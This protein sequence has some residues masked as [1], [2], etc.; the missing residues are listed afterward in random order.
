MKKTLIAL[1]IVICALTAK[2]DVITNYVY[3]VSN[4]F[5]NVY[6][7][8]VITQKVK[9]THTDY[10]F[11]NYVS[12]VTNVYQT[13]FQTNI[14]VDVIFDNF[15]PW[16]LAASNHAA[17][18]ESFSS[19]AA[20]SATTAGAS[21]STASAYANQAWSAA[22]AAE[23]AASSTASGCANILSSTVNA[24]TN[25]F[26]VHTGEMVTN[27]NITATTNLYIDPGIAIPYVNKVTGNVWNN[28]KVHA[29]ES[30]GGATVS[31]YGSETY[32][33]LHFNVWPAQ[34]SGSQY[35]EFGPAYIDSDEYGMRLQYVPTEMVEIPYSDTAGAHQGGKI[36]PEYLYWQDG[37]LYF[38]ANVWTNSAIAGYCISRVV[39]SAY[40]RPINYD[41]NNGVALA[42]VSRYRYGTSSSSTYN[43]AWFRTPTRTS[44]SFEFPQH[45]SPQ[46]ETIFE[47][48][49]T[50]RDPSTHQADT[51]ALFDMSNRIA[52]IAAAIG[53]PHA[54]VSPG[55]TTYPNVIYFESM[56]TDNKVAVTTVGDYYP[57][58]EYRVVPTDPG[59]TAN[60][61]WIFEPAYADTDENGLRLHYLP[62][63]QKTIASVRLDPGCNYVP[64]DFYWQNGAIYVVIDSYNGTTWQGR[65][66]L[67]LVGVDDWEYPSAIHATSTGSTLSTGQYAV[68]IYDSREGT[69][70]GTST[71]TSALQFWPASLKT[72]YNKV[73]P[74]YNSVLWFPE[75]PSTEQQAIIDW[76]ATW[77]R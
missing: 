48:M 13:T 49:C 40:P 4:I 73:L 16:V 59:D 53:N 56:L 47:W 70:M 37:Y 31:P 23:N 1:S 46:N 17:N 18:A 50:G 52:Q 25:W 10:Y 3:I 39:Y 12:V 6:S 41:N 11:T 76:L 72:E 32:S 57:S 35:W 77:T 44:G 2:A 43:G 7:E 8:L 71:A 30:D 60:G 14:E 63:Q 58:L 22:H 54:Y 74:S 21:A 61:Y 69:I 20:Q 34:R 36:I 27:V 66:R 75:S 28:I 26:N 64:R 38:K 24:F 62:K 65:I 19:D 67:K 9:S 33:S 15:E 45:I 68:L 29:W 55:G 51:D 5:N 42:A